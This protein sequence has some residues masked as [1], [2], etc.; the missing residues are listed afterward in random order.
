MTVRNPWFRLDR[1][2]EATTDPAPET[3]APETPVVEPPTPAGPDP[4]EPVDMAALP[5]NVRKLIADLR[6]ES[7][8]HRQK[9]TAAEQAAAAAAAQRDAILKA[10]GLNPDG[11]E[12]DD[13]EAAVSQLSEQLGEMH[14][15]LWRLSV[16][17]TV[18]SAAAR[19]GANAEMLLDSNAFFS[20][21]DP[22]VDDD[23]RDPEFARLV[24]ARVE[25][26]MLRDPG[27]YK[28]AAATPAGPPSPRPDRSQGRG[29]NTEPVDF[30]KASPE[31]VAEELAKYGIRSRW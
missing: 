27:R 22:H 20:T 23:P 28:T 14:D 18:R 7:G 9:A 8:G 12:A 19:L 29:G 10:A 30:R 25:E 6:K 21:L 15:H 1:H 5:A 13:P 2:D 31:A 11:S 17:S 16:D 3:A 24:E 26:A 4:S